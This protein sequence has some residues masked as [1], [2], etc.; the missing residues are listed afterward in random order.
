MK[1]LFVS[2]TD[3]NV[4]KT[5]VCAAL[6]HRLRPHTHV[7]YW[8]PVQTGIDVDDD[9]ESVRVLGGCGEAEIVPSAIRLPRPLS[10]H[11]AARLAGR[12]IELTDLLSHINGT[13]DG[14][15]WIIEGAGGAL[16][17]LNERELMVDVMARIAAPVLVV[18]RT[19]LGTIN[20]TLLTLA[21]LRARSLDIAGVVMVG[22]PS[23]EN[24][25]AIEQFG[26][27]PVLGELPRL[28]RL[29]TE[30][31]RQWALGSLDPDGRLLS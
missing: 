6:M 16:V 21:A 20:H 3:T 13:G 1:G 10:P 11:L 15:H 18:A 5:V 19:T 30:G 25:A 29:T 31:L 24:R 4:G 12:H 17:P 9:A 7:R 23:P 2:G 27:V 26:A 28:E 22:E 14:A 8:K